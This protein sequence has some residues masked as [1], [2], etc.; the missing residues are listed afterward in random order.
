MTKFNYDN[1]EKV[2]RDAARNSHAI[3]F[4]DR[5]VAPIAPFV[6]G[7]VIVGKMAYSL[8][9]RKGIVDSI[10]DDSTITVGG[11]FRRREE[12]KSNPWTEAEKAAYNAHRASESERVQQD[13]EKALK[14]LQ[15]R[16]KLAK[17]F[18]GR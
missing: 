9:G 3:A 15:E 4:V 14:A 18:L 17:G 7:E 5:H 11:Y 10:D 2:K 16:E 6:T 13:T 12:W 1:T 8:N